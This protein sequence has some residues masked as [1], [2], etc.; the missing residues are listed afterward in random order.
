MSNTTAVA[1]LLVTYTENG[2]FIKEPHG[3]K[4]FTFFREGD[5][6]E[7]LRFGVLEPEMSSGI[8]NDSL[9][10]IINVNWTGQ[11]VKFW[12][13]REQKI[14]KW[15][16]T[17]GGTECCTS[18]STAHVTPG[19]MIPLPTGVAVIPTASQTSPISSPS[20]S[21]AA[22]PASSSGLS[23]TPTA[24]TTTTSTPMN[25]EKSVGLSGGS[26]AGVAIGCL[27]AGALIAGLVLW[28][29]RSRRTSKRIDHNETSAIALISPEKGPLT[30]TKSITG[31]LA[32]VDVDGAL[33]QPL[34][35][36]AISGEITKISSLIKNHVQSYYHNKVVN[37]GLIDLDDITALGKVLPFPARKLS[38]LLDDPATRE[39]ALR[40]CIAW[41]I[42]SRIQS[43]GTSADSLLPPEV[44]TPMREIMNANDKSKAHVLRSARWRVTT[45]ELLHTTYVSDAFASSDPRGATIRKLSFILE[46]VLKPFADSRI[47]DDERKR[48]LVELLKRSAMF[49]FTLFSQPSTWTFDWREEQS[50]ESGE[51]CIFPALVQLTN[52]IGDPIVPPRSFSEAMTRRLE[53]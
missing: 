42:I 41:A 37:L 33:P 20:S 40:F 44:C 47:N 46:N 3:R 22:T 28:V 23:T 27:I 29:C 25:D 32:I 50:V 52:E 26:V 17:T 2:T 13:D 24:S 49:A 43:H 18:L 14:I 36:Q 34:E 10:T 8:P 53:G 16:S 6:T 15:D 12:W 5:S 35:D 19:G 39:V 9:Y 11:D 51:F 1:T 21:L 38:A 7:S 31:S 45:A 48:N 30:H 4:M